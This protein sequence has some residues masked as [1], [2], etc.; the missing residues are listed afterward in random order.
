MRALPHAALTKLQMLVPSDTKRDEDWRPQC[1]TAGM[2]PACPRSDP[3][4]SGQCPFVSL[5]QLL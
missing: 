5:T 2:G 3:A 4:W 1:D